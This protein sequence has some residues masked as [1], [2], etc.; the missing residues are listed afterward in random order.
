[1]KGKGVEKSFFNGV[2]AK[3]SVPH[4]VVACFPWNELLKW[5]PKFVILPDLKLCESCKKEIIKCIG[6][7]NIRKTLMHLT[8]IN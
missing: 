6:Y 8:E 4:T 3:L 2:V 1:M 5:L 7:F